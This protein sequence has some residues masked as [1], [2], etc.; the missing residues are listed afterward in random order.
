MV[1][2]S[3]AFLRFVGKGLRN[4]LFAEQ[5]E[6]YVKDSG[7]SSSPVLSVIE[8]IGHYTESYSTSGKRL[9]IVLKVLSTVQ[10]GEP[11]RTR[12]R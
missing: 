10:S 12:T 8:A 2:L 5:E 7:K 3:K 1:R 4:Y 9:K 11:S 6:G